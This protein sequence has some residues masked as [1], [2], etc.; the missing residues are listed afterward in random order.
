MDS[1]Q[2]TAF[3]AKV[4]NYVPDPVSSAV[5]VICAEFGWL[6]VICLGWSVFVTGSRS[7]VPKSAAASGV[8]D[9]LAML[10]M[11]VSNIPA[12][13]MF[14]QADPMAIFSIADGLLRSILTPPR[15]AKHKK[16]PPGNPIISSH[17]KYML[18][19]SSEEP[20][21]DLPS[22]QYA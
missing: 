11:G 7:I 9:R 13:R 5:A 15:I 14:S 19:G 20:I 10:P 21:K 1:S 18:L 12:I 6:C 16:A 3:I 22:P 8:A 4:S 17:N 2:F